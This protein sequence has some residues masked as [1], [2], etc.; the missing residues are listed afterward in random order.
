M[1]RV[2]GIKKRLESKNTEEKIIREIIGNGDLIN[3]IQR[4]E[5]LIEPNI[6][7]EILDSCA[8]TGGKKYLKYCENI[9]K[10]ITGKTLEEKVEFLNKDSDSEKIALKGDNT[11]TY[12]LSYKDNSKYK[13]LCSATVK[14]GI[15]VADIALKNEDSDDRVM[16]LSYCFCCAGSMCLHLQLKLGIELKAQEI[17]TSPINSKGEEPCRIIFEIL[18]FFS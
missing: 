10:E 15:K 2:E 9:G 14:K 6:M 1:A 5:Q 11:L 12:V 7:R 8:C 18:S 3:I 4:M 16:P 13:C 17:V